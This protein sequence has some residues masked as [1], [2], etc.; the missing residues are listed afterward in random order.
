MPQHDFSFPLLQ[1]NMVFGSYSSF[2]H[3]ME[4]AKRDDGFFLLSL[5]FR[6]MDLAESCTM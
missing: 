1:Q 4:H 3:T 6:S 5:S 2:L